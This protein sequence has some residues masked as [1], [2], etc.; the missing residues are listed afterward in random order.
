MN[1]DNLAWCTFVNKLYSAQSEDVFPIDSQS[2]I[3]KDF[4]V[5]QV[6]FMLNKTAEINAIKAMF[7]C[8]NVNLLEFIHRLIAGCPS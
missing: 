6:P 1:K 2:C 7:T 4:I 3:H 8:L 5:I